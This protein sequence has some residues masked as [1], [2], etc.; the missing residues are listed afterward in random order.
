MSSMLASTTENGVVGYVTAAAVT[1]DFFR[2]LGINPVQGRD[3][4]PR[5][6]RLGASPVVLIGGGLWNRRFGSNPAVIG[7]QLMLSGRSYTVAGIV[8]AGIQR[9]DHGTRAAADDDRNGA[10]IP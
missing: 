10:Q 5:A 3:F 4:A 7:S 9:R 8:P 2:V 1:G 6:D